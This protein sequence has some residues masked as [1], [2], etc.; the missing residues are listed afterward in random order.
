MN[1]G[2]ALSDLVKYK[3]I[4]RQTGLMFISNISVLLIGI[5][6][7]GIQTRGLG[8][9]AYGLFAFFLTITGFTVIFFR[10]GLFSSTRVLLLNNTDK[11]R[12]R[13]L[14][15]AGFFI[16]LLIGVSYFV[17]IFSISW[18]VDDI[19]HI[20]I[21]DIM[22]L[23][24]P[25]CFIL[26]FPFLID[27]L[28]VGSNKIENSALMNFLNKFL[29]FLAV[30]VLFSLKYLTL[31]TI[32]AAYLLTTLVVI[33]VMFFFFKPSFSNLKTTLKDIRVKNSQ[34]G[35]KVYL[36]Q[37][38]TLGTT[39]LDKIFIGYFVNT[40]WVGFYSLVEVMTLPIVYFSNALNDSILKDL[41]GL[42]RIPQ[43]LFVINFIWL[44]AT[45]VFLVFAGR[46]LLVLI[47]S[48]EYEPASTLIIPL[49]VASF[50]QGLYQP[51]LR[52]MTVNEKGNYQRNSALMISA[53]NLGT[54]MI[55]VPLMGAFGAALATAISR[56]FT[57]FVNYHYYRKSVAE[58]NS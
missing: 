43:K 12:E 22:R 36:G 55:M 7:K 25:L 32:I 2:F 52:F 56:I 48:S 3:K 26:P 29:F 54:N 50:F 39:Q 46:Y 37:I 47:F 1:I 28:A 17:F 16:T 38:V 41:S 57:F 33:I 4:V 10:F 34:Y 44:V 42:K 51:F 40:L 58:I 27:M 8:P 23:L 11:N 35:R 49:T 18:F 13:E 9:E 5:F 6:S 30:I 53:C 20:K 19:F 15:A 21:G 14:F 45:S 31:N 24:S